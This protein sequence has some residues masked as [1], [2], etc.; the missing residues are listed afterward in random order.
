MEHSIGVGLTVFVQ[1]GR[2]QQAADF[3]SEAFEARQLH[4]RSVDG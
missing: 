3:Y 2:E 1:H 4:K